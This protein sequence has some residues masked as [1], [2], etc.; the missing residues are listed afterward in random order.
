MFSPTVNETEDRKVPVFSPSPIPSR[1]SISPLSPSSSQIPASQD[2]V[3]Y[4]LNNLKTDFERITS[5]GPLGRS[6][7]EIRN[8]LINQLGNQSGV[9]ARTTDYQIEY[10]KAP[11]SFM[12]ELNSADPSAAKLSATDWFK[13]Q[14]LSTEG[15]CNL[16][17]VF[18]LSDQSRS[19]F[20]QTGQKFDPVPEGCK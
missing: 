5:P 7:S 14:G 18:Y 20:N 16:P 15:I 3:P 13:Q 2:S 1:F 19:Y 9:L 11:N 8:S 6:D 10:V 12:V 4:D 17:V